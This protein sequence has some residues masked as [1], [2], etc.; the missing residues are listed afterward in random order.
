MNTTK[1][2]LAEAREQLEQEKTS[3]L[4]YLEAEKAVRLS[5]FFLF[6][7]SSFFFFF[8]SFLSFNSSNPFEF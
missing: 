4:A 5:V 2:D 7:L 1:R 6:V 3:N 8:F